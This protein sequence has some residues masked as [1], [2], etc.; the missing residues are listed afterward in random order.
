MSYRSAFFGSIP[1]LLVLACGGDA[2]TPPA[3]SSVAGSSGMP[4]GVG[5]A[6]AQGGAPTAGGGVA[7]EAPLAGGGGASLPT[8]GGAPGSEAGAGTG[9]TESEAT[10]GAG[11]DMSAGAAGAESE[12]G[13]APTA[14]DDAPAGT[15]SPGCEKGGA[16]PDGGKVYVANKSWLIFPEGYDGKT[17]MPVLFG[18]HGCSSANFG[19][20]NRTEYWDLTRGNAFET[21]YVVA[22]P[23]SGDPGGG[24]W[25]YQRDIGGVL[26]L[27]DDLVENYCVDMDR[28]FATAHS[29]GAQ[30]LVE[31]LSQGHRADAEHL[32]FKGMAPVAASP[33]RD[34]TTPVA[35]MYVQGQMDNQRGN[36]D[37]K[38]VVD[39]YV[40]ANG[41]STSSVPYEVEGCA[42]E[43]G[44]RDVDP[45]CIEY[46]GCSVPTVWCSHNDP[47]YSGTQHG[48]PCFAAYA[49]D[50]FFKSL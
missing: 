41:C 30:F 26:A 13:G 49:M 3:A 40:A 34:H 36:S 39:G 29:S 19:D 1:F 44:G 35:V 32:N 10:A 21:D 18:F 45:G 47:N 38:P 4:A 31:V 22:V 20:A 27:Y 8:V 5:G 37:G 28:V 42:S 9:G 43:D 16:R 11:G 2:A 24:C 17:P 25:S 48:V 50:D 46:D 6:D 7:G 15:P 33:I 14:D 23:L 12:A